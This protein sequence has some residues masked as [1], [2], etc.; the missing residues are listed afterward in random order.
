MT[1]AQSIITH[2]DAEYTE[3]IRDALWR[4]INISPGLKTIIQHPLFLKLG[5]IKQ[6]GPAFL[7][8]PAATHTRLAHSLG[9]FHIAK[10]IIHSLI[11]SPQCPPLT[12]EGVKA[13]LCGCLLHDLGHFPFAHSLKELPLRSHENLTAELILNSSL[14]TLIRDNVKTEPEWVASIIDLSMKAEDNPEIL[15]YRQ[16]LSGVLDP[17]KLD[18]LNRDAFFSGVPYGVQDIDFII[19]RI[20]PHPKA[21]IAI[22]AQGLPAVENILFSKYLMYRSVY[23][24]KTVRI[25]TAMIK[26]GVY[27]ELERRTITTTDLYN[28]DDQQFFHKFGP[29]DSPSCS[30]ITDVAKRN[31]FK[32]IYEIP[33]EP[34]NDFHRQLTDLSTRYRVEKE[35][36]ERLGENRIANVDCTSVIID[37]PEP[38]SF[39]ID[40]PIDFNGE[41]V[42]FSESKSVF[43]IPVVQ[44]FTKSLRMLR[45]AS[46]NTLTNRH[47]TDIVTT[48]FLEHSS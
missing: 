46:E 2:L 15:F 11:H 43:S 26:K 22:N 12:L 44:G 13:F 35:L 23:W 21:G 34:K 16:L 17:D 20:E 9:V 10:R 29:N 18:Y 32:S 36:A 24:H 38:I 37:I 8:Y 27:L 40:M 39:E 31:L 5:R 45:V 25:A 1:E 48:F 7:V 4:N 33:F 42:P 47:S 28:I 3:P 19:D 30:L 6:L 14:V 41:Y